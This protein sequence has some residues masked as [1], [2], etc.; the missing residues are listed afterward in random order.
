L[1]IPRSSSSGASGMV[2]QEPE[3]REARP[4]GSSI[5]ERCPAG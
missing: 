5:T 3:G 2:I 1:V 4:S